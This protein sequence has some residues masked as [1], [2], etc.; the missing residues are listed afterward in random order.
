VAPASAEDV[1]PSSAP[2]S[3]AALAGDLMTSC[4]CR[5]TMLAD[6]SDA[7]QTAPT[8]AEEAEECRPSTPSATLLAILGSTADCSTRLMSLGIWRCRWAAQC[9]MEQPRNLCEEIRATIGP[10]RPLPQKPVRGCP[11]RHCTD[12]II[13]Q[14]L[15]SLTNST[16][17]WAHSPG[18][19]RSSTTLGHAASTMR[20]T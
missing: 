15:R 2:G 16:P 20:L 9:H 8:L 11:V 13:Y 19:A 6:S 10:H 3:V 18:P 17:G 7:C 12:P 1:C 5:K 4:Q 14:T